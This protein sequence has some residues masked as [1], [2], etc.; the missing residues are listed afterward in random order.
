MKCPECDLDGLELRI[1]QETW[2]VPIEITLNT[3]VLIDD[4][5][6]ESRFDLVCPHCLSEFSVN[7]AEEV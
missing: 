6:T 1:I 3:V 4:P 2:A 7:G 5:Q